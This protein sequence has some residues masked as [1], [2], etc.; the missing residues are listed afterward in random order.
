MFG[1]HSEWAGASYT[2]LAACQYQL[3]KFVESDANYD[4]AVALYEANAAVPR[5]R[6]AITLS[7]QANSLV[8][9]GRNEKAESIARKS[10]GI[11]LEMDDR[12]YDYVL[13]A[14]YSNLSNV[15]VNLGRFEESL[16]VHHTALLV[17]KRVFGENS[18]ELGY[19]YAGIGIVYQFLFD[20]TNAKLNLEK[21]I[22][23]IL[24]T[25]NPDEGRLAIFHAALASAYSE[26]GELT[27]ARNEANK[28]YE[29]I[30]HR[31]G[32]ASPW[33][34]EVLFTQAEIELSMGHDSAAESKV[35]RGLS[36][37]RTTERPIA[38]QA[39][40]LLTI[41]ALQMKRNELAVAQSTLE[42]ALTGLD[43]RNRMTR[44]TMIDALVGLWFIFDLRKQDAERDQIE[45]RLEALG[46]PS[47]GLKEHVARLNFA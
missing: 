19:D 8:E 35:Q 38:E 3:G 18:P 26:E 45:K 44:S 1:E 28:A 39:S 7:N 32:D 21:G 20:R 23:L 16:G 41:A 22:G 17:N 4:R 43:E 12:K 25:K 31:D 14:V 11:L 27:A 29:L 13:G 10:I 2:N 15:L 34:A 33:L 30:A 9:I 46:V 40:G 37:L 24:K 47:S 5:H 6:L 42:F 36:I